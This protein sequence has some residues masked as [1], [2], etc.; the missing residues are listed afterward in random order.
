LKRALQQAV[1][2]CMEITERD[3]GSPDAFGI[4]FVVAMRP[5]EYSGFVQLRR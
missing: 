3:R 5:W 1:R 2:E 4:A